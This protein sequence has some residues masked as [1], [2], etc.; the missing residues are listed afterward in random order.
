MRVHELAV[1]YWLNRNFFIQAG[2]P[3]PV[4][5]AP[6]A[7]AYSNFI[8]LWKSTSNPFKY[9]LDLK[10]ANG[11]PL[12]EPY[13][14]NV[15]YPLITVERRGWSFRRS[16]N[17]TLHPFRRYSWLTDQDDPRR[18][19]LSMVKQRQRPM[20]WDFLYQVDFLAKRP[21][22]LSVFLEKA[23]SLFWR[24]G[25]DTPQTWIIV[26]YPSW[27]QTTYVRVQL[28]GGE[29]SNLTPPSPPD[30]SAVEYRVSFTLR[31][32]GFLVDADYD[33]APAL[34]S[35]RIRSTGP[36][37]PHDFIWLF[38]GVPLDM[39]GSN[40]NEVLNSRSPLPPVSGPSTV[41]DE[42]ITV[43]F[44]ELYLT[45]QTTTTAIKM[46][47][48]G[49]DDNPARS[50][51]ETAGPPG[52][53]GQEFSFVFLR[54]RT[55]GS[56]VKIWLSDTDTDPAEHFA[57]TGEV[58]TIDNGFDEIRLQNIDSLNY[59]AMYAYGPDS[60]PALGMEVVSA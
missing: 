38:G 7:D 11:T 43:S 24:T 53:G 48:S 28:V 58:P 15:R 4:I 29:I 47:I 17:W 42:I 23:M 14:S 51:D 39:R 37:A 32:E 20:G 56:W 34:N 16:G 57:V 49:P 26:P 5:F 60:D 18:K 36:L 22:T 2:Y 54:S 27:F 45:N 30:G 3:I 59:I 35:L 50:Y 55:T 41:E 13:P 12:Y 19:D 6:V 25:G 44:S 40:T 1:Q 9:L 21:D 8:Q 10:D 33:V 52:P 46:V 31:V